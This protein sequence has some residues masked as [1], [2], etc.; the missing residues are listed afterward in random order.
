L[1]DPDTGKQ[2]FYLG[3]RNKTQPTT[4]YSNPGGFPIQMVDPSF[5][6]Y[7]Y[8]TLF[9]QKGILDFY[10]QNLPSDQQAIDLT[11]K[12]NT[13]TERDRDMGK[14]K[15]FAIDGVDVKRIKYTKTG[16]I[17]LKQPDFF[18]PVE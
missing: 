11:V 12:V 1:N 2:W 17:I 6:V 3:N 14:I 4:I 13:T 5:T 16:W 10:R 8:A 9:S 15:R 7:P 18:P